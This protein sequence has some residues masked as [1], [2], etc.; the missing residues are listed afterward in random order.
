MSEVDNMLAAVCII[1]N[2]VSGF[3]RKLRSSSNLN[4][5]GQVEE[6]N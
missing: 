6:G 5:T 1:E 4:F 2:E 3:S